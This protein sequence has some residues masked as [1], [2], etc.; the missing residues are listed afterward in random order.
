MS[1]LSDQEVEE[2]GCGVRRDK[3]AQSVTAVNEHFYM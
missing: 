2:D 3:A 1:R